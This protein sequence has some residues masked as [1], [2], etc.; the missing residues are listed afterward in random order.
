MCPF[1]QIH[2]TAIGPT[3]YVLVARGDGYPCAMDTALIHETVN[4][5]SG[6]HVPHIHFAFTCGDTESYKVPGVK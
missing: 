3:G 6:R 2:N 4:A 5:F 1:V